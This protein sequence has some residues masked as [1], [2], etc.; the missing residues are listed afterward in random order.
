MREILSKKAFFDSEKFS[1]ETA[2]TYS[3]YFEKT[4]LDNF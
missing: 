2:E 3:L 4:I 1:L